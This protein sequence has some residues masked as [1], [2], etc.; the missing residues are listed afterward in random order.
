MGIAA[1][2]EQHRNQRI[3]QLAQD[4]EAAA[5]PAGVRVYLVGSWARGDWSGASDIDLLVIGPEAVLEEARN[6]LADL[7]DDTLCISEDQW[8]H[9]KAIGDPW[10]VGLQGEAV[11]ISEAREPR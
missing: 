10:V 9:R 6:R 11:L 4:V 3:E 5:L 2:R 7:A 8:A 1:V